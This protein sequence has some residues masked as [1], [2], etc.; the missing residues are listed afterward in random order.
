MPPQLSLEAEES[1]PSISTSSEP[2]RIRRGIPQKAPRKV[3]NVKK[4][5][6]A[7]FLKRG[8]STQTRKAAPKKRRIKPGSKH[9]YQNVYYKNFNPK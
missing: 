7:A 5:T 6:K 8:R 2:V 4:K 3:P 9:V 1:A